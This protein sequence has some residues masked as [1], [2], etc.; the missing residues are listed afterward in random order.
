MTAY[1]NWG[2]DM[3]QL[4]SSTEYIYR[5][6]HRSIHHSK[7][8]KS[9]EVVMMRLLNILLAV[10]L[11]KGQ[12]VSEC[13]DNLELLAFKEVLENFD[14]M[15]DVCLRNQSIGLIVENEVKY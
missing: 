8:K 4:H 9:V 3:T 2:M 13:V 14:E 15:P 10:H 7:K 5:F 11:V 1:E 12:I 6:G